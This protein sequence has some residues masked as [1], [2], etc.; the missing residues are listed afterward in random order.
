MLN[1]GIQE[2]R[3]WT[4]YIICTDSRLFQNAVI[5]GA[6]HNTD[7]YLVLGCLHR[8]RP[9]AHL[10]YLGKCT[11]LPI[12]PPAP[13]DKADRMFAKLRGSIPKPPPG[14]RATVGPGSPPRPGVWL[15]PGRWLASRGT[16]TMQGPLHVQPRQ[17]F[18]GTGAERRLKRGQRLKPSLHPI[19]LLYA[20]H[21]SGSRCGDGI[22]I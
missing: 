8:A 16:N 6:W 17:N 14:R 12:R 7:H 13:L 5:K 2:V 9:V 22:R 19:R 1:Q 21:G 18:R 4:K 3:S 11:Y 10:R 15:K 20:R